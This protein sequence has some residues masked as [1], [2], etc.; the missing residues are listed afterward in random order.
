[1]EYVK[2]KIQRCLIYFASTVFL[3][4][5]SQDVKTYS[6]VAYFSR[7]ERIPETGE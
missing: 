4:M 2:S 6:S 1:M 7:S 5:F 3:R